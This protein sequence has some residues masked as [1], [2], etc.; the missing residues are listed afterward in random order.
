MSLP[1]CSHCFLHGTK[2]LPQLLD[3]CFLLHPAGLFSLESLLHV[4]KLCSDNDELGSKSILNSSDPFIHV[5]HCD[6]ADLRPRLLHITLALRWCT[7]T[8]DVPI[9]D[10]SRGNDLCSAML[11]TSPLCFNPTFVDCIAC[12]PSLQSRLPPVMVLA[13]GLSRCILWTG[14]I[15]LSLPKEV[16]KNCH[17]HLLFERVQIRSAQCQCAICHCCRSCLWSGKASK[18]RGSRLWE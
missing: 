11:S 6:W 12:A 13:L 18:L 9:N 4:L 17:H 5:L 3:L 8:Q 16:L 10:G 14:Q 7:F 2:I 1:N 15:L